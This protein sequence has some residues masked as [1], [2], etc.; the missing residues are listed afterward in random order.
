[1]N[2]YIVR[3]LDI[4]KPQGDDCDCCSLDSGG[5]SSQ[6][7]IISDTRSTWGAYWGEYCECGVLCDEGI[8][9]HTRFGYYV[10]DNATNNDTSLDYL[11]HHLRDEGY[12]GFE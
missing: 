1:M 7:S 12:D 10:G 4:T 6:N 11:D 2:P 3:P 8:H 9:I 5:L